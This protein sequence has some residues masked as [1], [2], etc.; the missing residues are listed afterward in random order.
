M[1][2]K[3]FTT[4]LLSIFGFSSCN[5]PSD[6]NSDIKAKPTFMVQKEVF[7]L[8]RKIDSIIYVA[9]ALTI[10]PDTVDLH[11]Y[12]INVSAPEAAIQTPISTK[13]LRKQEIS[14]IK[15]ELQAYYNWIPVKGN[16]V[17]FVQIQPS[18]FKD[19]M[20]M[21]NKRQEIEN[22]LSEALENKNLGQWFAG[23]LGPGGANILYTIVDIDKSL[24]VVLRVLHDN[25]L[26]KQVLIG[27]RVLVSKE[28][29][30]YEVIYPA[31]YSGQFNTM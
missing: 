17:L 7:S 8:Y 31:N 26:E 20:Q 27:R 14:N 12:T 23:D 15:T 2:S 18:G 19:E 6:K 1:R 13:Q 24:Q 9:R 11:L 3:A 22:K 21:L 16:E 30:F 4:A 5:L 29:W 28:D 10:N 25:D